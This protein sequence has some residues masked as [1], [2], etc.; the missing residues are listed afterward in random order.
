MR[1]NIQLDDDLLREAR[2]HS[3]ART[4]RALIEEALS[5]FIE[6]KSDQKKRTAY[7]ERL[8]DL[9]AKLSG[10]RLREK[11]SELLRQDRSR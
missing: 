7:A 5:T 11:P 3:N 8:Q 9:Q 4:K 1:T 2:K 10:L 6:V